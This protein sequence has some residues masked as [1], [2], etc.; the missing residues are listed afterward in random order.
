MLDFNPFE[1]DFS[2][3][4]SEEYLKKKQDENDNKMD[5]CDLVIDKDNSLGGAD[6]DNVVEAN[7]SAND[8]NQN[9]DVHEKRMKVLRKSPIWDV[10]EAYEAIHG[11][12]D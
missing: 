11:S 5:A 1:F 12:L 3:N 10:V 4:I 2:K 7:L 6:S 9:T 8:D